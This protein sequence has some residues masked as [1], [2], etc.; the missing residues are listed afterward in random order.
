MFTQHGLVARVGDPLT[1]TTNL[2]EIHQNGGV[3]IN[4]FGMVAFHGKVGAD[5][6]VVIV[7]EAPIPDVSS[8]E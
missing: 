2:G 4:F 5:T 3:A 1:D 7:G 8:T 6:D